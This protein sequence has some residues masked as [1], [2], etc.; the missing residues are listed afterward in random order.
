M[1][2][3]HI[4]EDNFSQ[5]TQTHEMVVLDFWATWCGPCRQFAPVFEAASEKHQDLVFGK[6]DTDEEQSLAEA[7]GIRS[8]PTLMIIREKILVARESGALP[9]HA[10]EKL[11]EQAR[12]IDMD[13]LRAEIAAAE[14]D[15]DAIDH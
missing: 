4:T 15:L 2:T 6:I 5:I 11:I 10:L 13:D 9:A 14:G 8:V 7:F 1:A 3:L 12:L